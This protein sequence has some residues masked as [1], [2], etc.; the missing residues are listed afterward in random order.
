MK[1]KIILFFAVLTPLLFAL[2]APTPTYAA[3]NPKC[4]RES[5]K[6]D[7]TPVETQGVI[8]ESVCNLI[9]IP[10][11]FGEFL[12]SIAS[13]FL[14]FLGLQGEL[15]FSNSTVPAALQEARD[16]SLSGTESTIGEEDSITG[17]IAKML[18]PGYK[19]KDS[20]GKEISPLTS[21][22]R[23]EGQLTFG[24]VVLNSGTRK[25]VY[26]DIDTSK[27]HDYGLE[28][29]D[30]ANS[31]ISNSYFAD[32]VPVFD[33][34]SFLQRSL[35][36]NAGEFSLPD[37]STDCSVAAQGEEGIIQLSDLNRDV[38]WDAQKDPEFEED[39]ETS[40]AKGD[41]GV[42]S[43]VGFV[44]QLWDKLAVKSDQ[45][46]ESGVF[47]VLLPPETEFKVEDSK[48]STTRTDYDPNSPF[49][50]GNTRNNAVIPIAYLGNVKGAMDCITNQLTAHPSAA[51]VGVC[52]NAFEFFPGASITCTDEA[53]PLPFPNGAGSGIARRA[54]EIM[55]N[56]YQGF[57]CFWNWSK[58]DYPSIFDEELFRRNPNPTREEVQND[59]Q[60]LFWCTW[61]VWKTQSNHGPSLNS[62]AMKNYYESQ[63]RFVAP[64]NA[65]VQNV[66]P[67]YVV[68]FDVFNSIN[69]L[70][71]VGVVYSV[72]PDSITFVQSNA[73]TKFDT[74]TFRIGA[75]VNNLPWARV[76]GFGR[77]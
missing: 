32:I 16:L 74:I 43:T 72:T 35:V 46:G 73:F 20:T 56:M 58:T 71:H 11:P 21:L 26:G 53:T 27:P 12:C 1:V 59:S 69:R 45:P 9:P 63:G 66:R 68:F 44:K 41:L 7:A 4:V 2:L 31:I 19:E 8:R 3:I 47:N 22:K 14:D 51:A 10:G 25:T 37:T 70:D 61:L 36:P 29:G 5:S 23:A 39:E 50:S 24:D 28:E 67:G 65:T 40:T 38:D 62:Q 48:E 15:S 30:S 34:F 64:Q 54:W 77:P 52:E 18:P 60:S 49:T 6:A 42:S 33:R 13:A 75:G 55:N 76:G 17:S 57:W